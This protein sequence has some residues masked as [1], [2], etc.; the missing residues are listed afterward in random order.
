M[1]C[2]AIVLNTTGTT[3]ARKQPRYFTWNERKTKDNIRKKGK[4]ERNG[5]KRKRKNMRKRNKYSEKCY[6]QR[7]R[8]GTVGTVA[9]KQKGKLSRG[10]R[11]ILQ[12]ALD[13]I[14]NRENKETLHFVQ[15]VAAQGA[16]AA[17]LFLCRCVRVVGHT[18]V[19]CTPSLTPVLAVFDGS[20][21]G[22]RPLW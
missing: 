14:L 6:E 13:L 21:Q 5:E 7:G 3:Y 9:K 15:Q 10:R 1:Q 2:D 17:H 4:E 16:D 20:G 19:T 12:Q 22:F 11:M 18:F 8:C